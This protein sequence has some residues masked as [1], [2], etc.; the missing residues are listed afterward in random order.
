[1]NGFIGFENPADY[2]YEIVKYSMDN[3]I[4]RLKIFLQNKQQN[5]VPTAEPSRILDADFVGVGTKFRP[6]LQDF[7]MKADYT[8]DM[9]RAEI[10][11]VEDALGDNYAGFM[12]WNPNNIYTHGA[13]QK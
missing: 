6:W 5:L 9:V 12:L 1:I 4:S 3:A 11:A 7:D 8:A 13:I 2:P 10:R